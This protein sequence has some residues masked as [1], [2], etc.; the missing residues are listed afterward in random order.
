VNSESTDSTVE[1]ARAFGT[2]VVPFHYYGGWPKKRQWALHT[3]A[4]VYDLEHQKDRPS[5]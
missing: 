2:K 3:K 1:I 5:A 4:K